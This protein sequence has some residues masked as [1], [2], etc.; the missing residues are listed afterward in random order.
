VSTLPIL[1]DGAGLRVLVVGGGNVATRKARQF[2]QAGAIVRIVSP[3]LDSVLE[4]LV[5]EYAIV[6]ER[7]PYETGDIVDAQL[8][9]CATSD[10]A[11]NTMVARD[12]EAD[13]RLLNAAD[14][15]PDGNFA[16]MATHHRGPLTIGVSAG[17]VPA[18][19][20]RIR[21][22]IAE[23]FDARYGDALADLG[24]LRRRTIARGDSDVWRARSAELID[25]DFCDAVEHGEL[26]QRI[27]EWP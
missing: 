24:A 17:G 10:R 3:V 20:I 15:A 2:A 26:P 23:R 14:H 18:A 19:A 4:E 21:D 11:A 9:I 7:R 1:L 13:N 22:A 8:V 5:L 16:M 27:A 25:R 6:V 12:A